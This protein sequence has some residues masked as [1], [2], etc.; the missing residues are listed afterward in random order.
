VHL[1]HRDAHELDR[2]V[3]CHV[4]LRLEKDQIVPEA[5]DPLACN[6]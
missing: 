2:Y 5:T 3:R 4:P 1:D 6:E